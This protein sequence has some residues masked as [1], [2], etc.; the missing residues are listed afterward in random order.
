MS[1]WLTNRDENLK[2]IKVTIF[3][4]CCIVFAFAFSIKI[5][6]NLPV[7]ESYKDIFA[8]FQHSFISLLLLFITL[9]GS[10]VIVRVNVLCRGSFFRFLF[11]FK[12]ITSYTMTSNGIYVL[13]QYVSVIPPT[14]E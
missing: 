9:I 1:N 10:V 12:Q 13:V 4:L 14:C 6:C 3:L 5:N 2:E 7:N 8:F 11:V